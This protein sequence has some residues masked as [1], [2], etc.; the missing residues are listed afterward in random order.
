MHYWITPTF[1]VI[2][3]TNA[4]SYIDDVSQAH[5]VSLFNSDHGI[6]YN[7]FPWRFIRGAIASGE[8]VL[9]NTT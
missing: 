2:G 5:I 9:R 6:H 7:C 1:K 4:S 8:I 3:V